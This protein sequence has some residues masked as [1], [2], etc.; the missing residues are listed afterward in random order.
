MFEFKHFSS[1]FRN[2][3]FLQSETLLKFNTEKR[4]VHRLDLNRMSYFKPKKAGGF[5]VAAG[6]EG[7]C[8]IFLDN[9]LIR[10]SISNN[11]VIFQFYI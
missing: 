10:Y 4:T 6:R 7:H 5:K 3:R 11:K 8:W 2:D 1:Q 9:L